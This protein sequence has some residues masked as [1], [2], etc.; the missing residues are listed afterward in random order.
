MEV[1]YTLAR[2]TQFTIT[3]E[4]KNA[5][6]MRTESRRNRAEASKIFCI[7]YI[8]AILVLQ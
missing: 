1:E 2:R 8:T 6:I 7:V 5:L 3:Y 4:M